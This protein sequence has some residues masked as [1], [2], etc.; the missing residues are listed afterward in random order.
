MYEA[1]SPTSTRHVLNTGVPVLGICYGHQLIAH[2]LGGKVDK[3]ERG[4]YGIAQLQLTS[5]DELWTG[6]EASQ[7]WMSHQDSV[8]ELPAG[9]S[10][11]ASTG[12]SAVAAMADRAR[13]LYGCNSTR[14]LYTRMRETSFCAT[15]CSASA[16]RNPIG[17]SPQRVPAIEEQIQG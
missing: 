7:I 14:K 10:V 15:S 9:F 17:T 1:G 3:G 16:V 13:R 2:H 11:I 5:D 4:E 12:T 8:A 6:V